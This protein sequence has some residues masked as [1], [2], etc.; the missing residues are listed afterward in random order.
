M[1]SPNIVVSHEIIT[2]LNFAH[3]SRFNG[4]NKLVPRKDVKA[5]SLLLIF[6]FACIDSGGADWLYRPPKHMVLRGNSQGSV[7]MG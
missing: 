3:Y 1:S 2:S 5:A 4:S 7:C 6:C